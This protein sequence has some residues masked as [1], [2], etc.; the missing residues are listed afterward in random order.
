MADPSPPT[1]KTFNSSLLKPHVKY[2]FSVA[3][4]DDHQYFKHPDRNKMLKDYYLKKFK[5][6]GHSAHIIMVLECSSPRTK[7]PIQQTRLHFHG[8]ICFS[9]IGIFKFYAHNWN[10][11][12]LNSLFE[13]DTIDCPETWHNYMYKDA[14][15]MIP[16]SKYYNLDYPFYQNDPLRLKGKP[17]LKSIKHAP[18]T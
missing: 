1:V 15:I 17:A 9:P 2:T 6:L 12:L 11:L 18:N 8:T 13:I 16:Y 4:D 10:D 5:K 14:S 3:P 7:N